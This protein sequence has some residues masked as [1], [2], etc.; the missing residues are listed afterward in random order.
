MTD[1]HC[2]QFDTPLHIIIWYTHALFKPSFDKF[3]SQKF[4]KTPDYSYPG[5]CSS[6]AGQ[7]TL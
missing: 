2:I 7:Q 4:K 1:F 5:S 3:R 6:Y